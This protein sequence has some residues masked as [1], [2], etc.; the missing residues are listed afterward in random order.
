MR[1]PACAPRAPHI[2]FRRLPKASHVNKFWLLIE[3]RNFQTVVKTQKA[4]FGVFR[5]TLSNSE[6]TS[7]AKLV[8]AHVLVT[9]GFASIEYQ[10]HSSQ[11]SRD[12]E[13][14]DSD[15][16]GNTLHLGC[17][18]WRRFDCARCVFLP[19]RF[20]ASASHLQN[21]RILW[22]ETSMTSLC[23]TCTGD[24]ANSVVSA[25]AGCLVF[26]RL[27]WVIFAGVKSFVRFA[28]AESPK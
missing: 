16:L 11:G 17:C 20:Q 8:A 6:A 19:L 21:W 7:T 25:V 2:Y 3:F 24:S 13:M 28:W 15:N 12:L 22:L 27:Q 18:L 26:F 14:Y 1:V 4:L 9:K 10:A 23:S 5:S